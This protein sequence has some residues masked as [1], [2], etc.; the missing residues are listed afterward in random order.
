M[1]ESFIISLSGLQ[2]D[3]ACFNQR[4]RD[5]RLALGEHTVRQFDDLQRRVEALIDYAKAE[6]QRRESQSEAMR[7]YSDWSANLSGLRGFLIRLLMGRK[8]RDADLAIFCSCV[9]ERV[10]MELDRAAAKVIEE[11]NADHGADRAA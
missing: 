4:V 9:S 10:H 3:L 11:R 2:A 5:N 7:L 1:N 6:G 8:G